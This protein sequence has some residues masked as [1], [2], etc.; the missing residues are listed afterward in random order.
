[1]Y[2]PIYRYR[3]AGTVEFLIDSITNQF[4]FCE[5]NT[6]LQVEHPITEMVTNVDLVHW[7]FLVAL[8]LP[9]PL[10]QGEIESQA[11]GVAI[12]ARIYAENCLNN[13]L[14]VTGLISHISNPQLSMKEEGIR[15]DT[16]VLIV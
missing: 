14:P 10:S 2:A 9:L 1:M 7:Q 15:V 11:K 6:R 5:M 8:N 3:G 13:F 12:E 4:Y 16:G